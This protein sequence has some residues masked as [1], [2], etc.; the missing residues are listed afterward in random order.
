MSSDRYEETIF[1]KAT[2][3]VIGG[4]TTIFFI[5]WIYDLFIGWTIF[6]PLGSWFWLILFIFFLVLTFNF[7]T[8]NIQIDQDGIRVGYGVLKKK[9]TWERVKDSY[10]DE[11][12][13]IWYGG[14]GVRLARIKGNWRIVYNVMRGPRVI[15]SLT[16]G[17]ITEFVFSSK[18]P[19][20]VLSTIKQHLK[21]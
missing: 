11:T 21:K 3:L 18:N 12:S 15:V 7:S 6:D 2:I 5:M 14:W 20:K 8:L 17:W 1:S 19:K 13:V 16:D 10:I 4:C 9:I